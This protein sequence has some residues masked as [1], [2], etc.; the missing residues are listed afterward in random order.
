M[1]VWEILGVPETSDAKTIRQAYADKLKV[2]RP[3]KDPE[4]YQAL[5]EAYD[6]A[7]KLEAQPMQ[8][9]G[10]GGEVEPNTAESELAGIDETYSTQ[11]VDENERDGTEKFLTKFRH[12]LKIDAQARDRGAWTDLL[13]DEVLSSFDLR[14]Q[15]EG[16]CFYMLAEHCRIQKK[17]YLSP[18]G[19]VARDF[20]RVFGWEADEWSFSGYHEAEETKALMKL[21]AS[22]Q[23]SEQRELVVTFRRRLTYYAKLAGYFAWYVFIFVWIFDIGP[24]DDGPKRANEPRGVEVAKI[25]MA[26]GD[27]GL[28]QSRLA[29]IAEDVGAAREEDVL[30]LAKACVAV[31]DYDIADALLN[32]RIALN[33]SSTLYLARASVS[34]FLN[35]MNYMRADLIAAANQKPK[36]YSAL[37]AAAHFLATYPDANLRDPR[38]ALKYAEEAQA[39]TPTGDWDMLRILANAEAING[40]SEAALAHYYDWL[41]RAQRM[42][43]V[44]V[45]NIYRSGGFVTVDPHKENYLL[46]QDLVQE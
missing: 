8:H 41:V 32:K 37:K 17:P 40:N 5:R 11:W 21:I 44:E 19:V 3:D 38:L 12:L 31:G 24:F 28:A 25:G 33:P 27:W 34:L 16:E 46:W 29:Y 45:V 43:D 15:I 6:L 23:G 26:R 10:D 7:L 14:K 9:N 22:P 13:R 2:T 35:D 42:T 20:A 1:D 36:R 18:L 4:G 39:L 30:L